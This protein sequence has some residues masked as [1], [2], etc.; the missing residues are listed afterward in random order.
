MIKFHART[1]VGL[2]R[3]HNEDALLAD[4][5]HG[6]FVV[7]DGVGG[8]KAGEIASALTVNAFQ[9]AGP[10]LAS[11]V[12]AF[13]DDR[14][15]ARRNAVLKMLDETANAASKMVYENA[16]ET[17]R[18]GMTTTLVASVIGG[19]AAFLAHVGDSRAYLLRGGKLRQLTEDHS[20]VNE[21]IR[22]GSM[23]REEAATSRYRNVI[24][25]AIG[26]YPNVRCDTMYVELLEGDRIVLCSDGMSDLVP[27]DEI[28]R[29]LGIPSVETGVDELIAASLRAGG[30]DNI[31]VIGLEPEAEL[32]AATV[33]ARARA[34]ER[35]FLFEDLPFPAR[36][37][38]SRMVS[39]LYVAP[40]QVVVTQGDV[41]DTLYV[42]V[43][44]EVSVR[45]DGQ[46]IARLGEGEHFGELSL[47]DEQPRSA[48][49]VATGFGHL[50]GIDRSAFREFCVHEPALGNTL[51]WKLVATLSKRLRST[52]K[53]LSRPG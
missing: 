31:T 40:D 42:V 10:E 20:M 51:M 53:E 22:T 41:G 25:R 33:A 17:G 36:L 39:E 37:R 46:E 50:L 19:G 9:A 24:T 45:V 47:V 7:A 3:K 23:T 11:A 48:D 29:M 30:K 4:E 49:I 12:A 38:V 32:E 16:A 52:N 14:T 1:D 26:L 5:T 35:L 15:R 28:T 6:V 27:P 8:R 2:K 44:G 43:Q 18:Q 34:M 21:L 13:T